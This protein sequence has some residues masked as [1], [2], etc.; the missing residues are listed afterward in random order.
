M[1]NSVKK[2]LISWL[3]ER[4]IESSEPEM[5]KNFRADA[6]FLWVFLDHSRDICSHVISYVT[7]MSEYNYYH[8]TV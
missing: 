4:T 1:L 5:E 7:R 3:K 6:N 8:Q 2:I